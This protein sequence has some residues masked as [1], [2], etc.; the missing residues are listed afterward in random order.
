MTLT[1]LFYIWLA[2][3][4]VLLAVFI[5]R[6]KIEHDRKRSPFLIVIYLILI[7]VSVWIIY[8]TNIP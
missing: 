5:P 1:I 7:G 6:E 8:A 2:I 4:L 3:N